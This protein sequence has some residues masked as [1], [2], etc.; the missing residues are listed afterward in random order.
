MVLNFLA[1][2]AA[3]VIGGAYSSYISRSSDRR[4]QQ[5]ALDP[6]LRAARREDDLLSLQDQ[7]R[8]GLQGLKKSYDFYKSVGLTPQEIVGTGGGRTLGNAAPGAGSS[9]LQAAMALREN[10]KSRAL[11]R[12]QTDMG[13]L[14]QIV[15]TALQ[16]R[17]HVR[18]QDLQYGPDSLITEQRRDLI[19]TRAGRIRKLQHEGD[20][21]SP[22]FVK[23]MKRMTMAIPNQLSEVL[24][25][26]FETRYGFNPVTGDAKEWKKLKPQQRKS[27][28]KELLGYESRLQ[29]EYSGGS[30]V[31]GDIVGQLK[32]ATS[33]FRRDHQDVMDKKQDNRG[34][35]FWNKAGGLFRRGRQALGNIRGK[36]S[37]YMSNRIDRMR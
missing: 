11:Q 22:E 27:F 25:K 20:I 16:T 8:V 35:S 10:A 37:E 18:G 14:T 36:A 6:K 34:Q 26:D 31:L 12:Y 4:A 29:T 5:A 3:A 1:P 17:A 19:S 9:T 15:S 32:S 13:A 33:R 30:G 24:G 21:N 2:I 23:A 7:Q 28:A